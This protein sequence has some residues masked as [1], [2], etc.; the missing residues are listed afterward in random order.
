MGKRYTRNTRLSLQ[1]SFQP[2]AEIEACLQRQFAGF[3]VLSQTLVKPKKELHDR[4]TEHI[5]AL[6]QVGHASAV[7]DHSTSTVHKIKW[8][9][10]EILASGQ[11]DLHCKIKE[12]PLTQDLKPALNLNGGFEKLRSLC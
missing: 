3:V 2:L 10:L 5:K 1:R 12:I 9:H 8:D 7:A 4:N 6:T 11:C